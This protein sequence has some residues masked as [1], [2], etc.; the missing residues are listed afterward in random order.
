[1]VVLF[2]DSCKSPSY[3]VSRQNTWE[4]LYDN[5]REPSALDIQDDTITVIEL[6]CKAKPIYSNRDEYPPFDSEFIITSKGDVILYEP[7]LFL[8]LEKVK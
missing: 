1:M 4:F 8:Y 7:E 5:Y 3:K 2:K 6:E